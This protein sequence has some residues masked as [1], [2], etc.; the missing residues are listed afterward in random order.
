MLAGE[1][2]VVQYTSLLS[3]GLN[4]KL[5]SVLPNIDVA[6]ES[7][8]VWLIFVY[9][10]LRLVKVTPAVAMMRSTWVT[11]RVVVVVVVQSVKQNSCVQSLLVFGEPEISFADAVAPAMAAAHISTDPNFTICFCMES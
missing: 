11:G 7:T 6:A 3:A 5:E 2:P 4:V 10:G 8:V 1:K 9:T